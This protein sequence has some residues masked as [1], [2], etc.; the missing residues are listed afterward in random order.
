MKTVVVTVLCCLWLVVL[1]VAGV[2]VFDAPRTWVVRALS[3]QD[4]PLAAVAAAT[5]A[6]STRNSPADATASSSQSSSAAA[7]PDISPRTTYEY[8]LLNGV[9]ACKLTQLGADGWHPIEYGGTLVTGYDGSA[10]CRNLG[11][12]DALDWALLERPT[13]PAQ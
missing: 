11:T 4:A 13:T 12:V 5:T 6:T 9:T 10:A 1:I 3:M 8:Q 7:A 2:Y